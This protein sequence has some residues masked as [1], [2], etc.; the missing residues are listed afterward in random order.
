MND[1]YS[2]LKSHENEKYLV[3]FTHEYKLNS[4]TKK[5]IEEIGAY[6]VTKQ[7]TFSNDFF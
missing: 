3:V 7:Y 2:A 1:L 4:K 5:M 6:G